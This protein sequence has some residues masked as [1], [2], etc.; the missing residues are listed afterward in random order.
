MKQKITYLLLFVF[1]LAA[2]SPNEATEE[3]IEPEVAAPTI[4]AAVEEP[5]AVPTPV[6]PTE[7]PAAEEPEAEPTAVPVEEAVVS[8]PEPTA[9]PVEEAE[10]PVE[11]ESTEAEVVE[12]TAV[13]VIAGRTPEGAFFLGDPNAP[14]TMI[15]YSDFL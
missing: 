5:T 10:A 15:D 11:E 3:T 9:V 1:I 12:E 6:P 13:N 14:L 2:C 8:E 4:V 7:V